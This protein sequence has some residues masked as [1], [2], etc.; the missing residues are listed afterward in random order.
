MGWVGWGLV[1]VLQSIAQESI[2][3]YFIS[4]LMASP[5][6]LRSR[7]LGV[8]PPPAQKKH[9]PLVE[10]SIFC[11]LKV[12]GLLQKQLYLLFVSTVET[13]AMQY[14]L[15]QLINTEGMV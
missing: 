4:V 11:R 2:S 8:S 6:S 10:L 3:R 13:M 1:P 5:K 7:H 12:T 9:T 15:L 14:L